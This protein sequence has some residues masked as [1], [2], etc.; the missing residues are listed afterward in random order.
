[1]LDTF[2]FLNLIS[3][4]ILP[5][6]LI[7]TRIG[8]IF[9]AIPPFRSH[10]L[11]NILKILVTLSVTILVFPLLSIKIDI[12]QLNYFQIFYYLLSEFICGLLIGFLSSIIFF[13]IEFAGNLIDFSSG[14][15]FASI[16]NPLTQENITLTSK[17]YSLVATTL[18]FTIGGPTILLQVIIESYKILPMASFLNMNM[19]II[20]FIIKDFAS[21]FNIGLKIAAPVAVALFL[22]DVALA[23]ISRAIPQLNVFMLGFSVKIYVL[24]IILAITLINTVPYLQGLFEDSFL[25]IQNFIKILKV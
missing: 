15:A 8:T 16:I 22:S 4:N 13:A 2:N 21:I 9:F 20:Q 18:F 3:I 23:I 6:F 14:F 1:M 17:F 19:E 24:F 11:P 25:N 12:R 10:N 7:M 5:F